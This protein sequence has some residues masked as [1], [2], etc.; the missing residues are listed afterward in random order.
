MLL[1]TNK[2]K[3]LFR[4]YATTLGPEEGK[5]EFIYRY[6]HLSCVPY[7]SLRRAVIMSR[8]ALSTL[9]KS[10]SILKRSITFPRDLLSL[11]FVAR[12]RNHV[13]CPTLNA[14]QF[15]NEETKIVRYILS[16]IP[17]NNY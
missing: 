9:V 4:S 11:G 3:S 10:L 12:E 8:L 15:R 5:P 16:V 6:L 7:L 1:W 2:G 17:L 13:R 14:L